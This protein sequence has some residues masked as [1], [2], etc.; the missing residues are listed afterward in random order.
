M[1]RLSNGQFQTE[2]NVQ[3]ICIILVQCLEIQF[4]IVESVSRKQNILHLSCNVD[5]DDG[6]K[7]FQLKK[8]RM[9]LG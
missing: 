4:E 6:L 1:A 8:G 3:V 9:D 7:P 5:T 2:K